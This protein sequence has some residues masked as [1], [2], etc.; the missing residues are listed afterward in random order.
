M[1]PCSAGGPT[2]SLVA[3]NWVL[4]GCYFDL[5]GNKIFCN[6]IF[7]LLWKLL[8]VNGPELD[9][10]TSRWQRDCSFSLD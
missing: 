4:L 9:V 1:L 3:T 8:H 7:E 5:V 2:F 10:Y 6:L